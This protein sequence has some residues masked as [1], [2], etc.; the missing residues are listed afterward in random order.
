MRLTE[1][2]ESNRA[3]EIERR[4]EPRTAER[5]TAECHT[6]L[7]H[8]GWLVRCTAEGFEVA[9]VRLLDISRN[10]AMFEIEEWMTEGETVVLG[11]EALGLSWC[12]GINV[13]R[14]APG[15]RK[16][17]RVHVAFTEPCPEEF[18]EAALQGP[19]RLGC[20]HQ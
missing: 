16:K 15:R 10:G 3:S 6:V 13:V 2:I 12:L 17:F 14:V 5:R 11:L 19:Q 4:V 20:T 18:Y 9:D 8:Q 7:D 1:G